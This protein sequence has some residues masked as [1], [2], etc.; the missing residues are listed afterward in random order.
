MYWFIVQMLVESQEQKDASELLFASL[1]LSKQ[2][3]G[4]VNGRL[5]ASVD[6]LVNQQASSSAPQGIVYTISVTV[7]SYLSITV[8]TSV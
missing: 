2:M 7:A 4:V 1:E 3:E 6:T 8:S 5:Q